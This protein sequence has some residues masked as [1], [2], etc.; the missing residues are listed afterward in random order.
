[1]KPEDSHE[2]TSWKLQSV[3]DRQNQMNSLVCRPPIG[4]PTNMQ[5][6]KPFF[7]I[8]IRELHP[9]EHSHDPS[10]WGEERH[11]KYL[12]LSAA[13]SALEA[14]AGREV[15]EHESWNW[16]SKHDPFM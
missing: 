16:L 8:L 6:A 14:I 9:L 1:M 13:W 11:A 10:I 2:S 7:A 4:F 12:E 3:I 15:H 5:E